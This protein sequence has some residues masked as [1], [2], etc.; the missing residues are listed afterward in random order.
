[1]QNEQ[2][3]NKVAIEA[4]FVIEWAKT[5]G[6]FIEDFNSICFDEV[7]EEAT[8]AFII[9]QEELPI[10]GQGAIFE[11]AIRA[12]FAAK[13]IQ[14]HLK[15]DEFNHP[16]RNRTRAAFE[17]IFKGSSLGLLFEFDDLQKKV[18]FLQRANTDLTKNYHNEHIEN[19]NIKSEMDFIK[20][21]VKK[22]Q[23]QCLDLIEQ[24]KRL[25]KFI[26]G[27]NEFLDCA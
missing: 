7:I 19:E 13:R 9:Q 10:N 22:F 25:K 15:V 4:N 26:D 24:D 8:T 20:R 3:S 2:A 17:L 21:D 11:A 14:Y 27:L 1:M 23:K 5:L 18:E 16:D 6:K 12:L